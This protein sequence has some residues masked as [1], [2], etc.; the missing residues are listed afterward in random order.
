MEQL[1]T[2][3]A[4]RNDDDDDDDDGKLFELQP[5]PCG[6]DGDQ[7]RIPRETVS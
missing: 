3:G 5:L 7:L 6:F 2:G 4:F 1:I